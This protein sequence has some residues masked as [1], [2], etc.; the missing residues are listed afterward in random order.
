MINDMQYMYTI[1]IS[2]KNILCP[3]RSAVRKCIWESLEGGERREHCCNYN[4]ISKEKRK[5]SV[6]VFPT[7]TTTPPA[8]IPQH[9][10]CHIL[11]DLFIAL[12]FQALKISKSHLHNK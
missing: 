1:R 3:T 6:K 7:Y 5:A 12:T 2:E 4:I 9:S 8:L 10:R 11:C